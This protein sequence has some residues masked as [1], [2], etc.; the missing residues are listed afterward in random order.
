MT[1]GKLTLIILSAL[2]FQILWIAGLTLWKR[3]R[4]EDAKPP[5]TD[6]EAELL[7]GWTGWRDLRVI[8]R[9]REDIA[10]TIC[11]F[12]LQALDGGML[13]GFLPGQ[14]L[15]FQVRT[16]PDAKERV[17]C[18]SLSAIGDDRNYRV[19]IKRAPWEPGSGGSMPISVYFHEHVQVGDTVKVRAPTGRFTLDMQSPDP[20]VLIAGGIGITP[21]LSMLQWLLEHQPKRLVH[22]F[23]G[24]RNSREMAFRTDIDVW[25]SKHPQFSRHLVFDTP[26]PGDSDLPGYCEDRF[27]TTALL[28]QRIPHGRAQFYL[29]GPNAMMKAL[30][31]GLRAWGVPEQDVHLESFGPSALAANH[32]VAESAIPTAFK[33]AFCHS[34]ITAEWDGSDANLL[35]FSE[36][37]GV[38]I[39]SACRGGNCG[40]CETKIRK[41][42]VVY[43]EAPEF[44]VQEGYCLPCVCR[45]AGHLELEA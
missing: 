20:V 14:Y 23:Y 9:T 24:A 13:P 43:Q 17:R 26:A 27:I 40:T 37:S 39:E 29:C 45:P 25:A 36:R 6:I 31:E 8:S 44:P 35:D 32:P 16:A 34:D 19:S 38:D 10:G 22:L 21:L 12:T 28:Q 4:K 42:S 15:N 41:G 30:T 2:V 7:P 3:A 33:I 11:T 18:Y 5:N 1:A